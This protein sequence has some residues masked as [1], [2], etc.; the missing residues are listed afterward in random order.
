MTLE[1]IG[2]GGDALLCMIEQPVC[3]Q[4]LYTGAI[5]DDRGNWYFP[6]GTRI[7]SSGDSLDFNR[8]SGQ[9]VVRLNRRQGRVP[10]IYH[11]EIPNEMN[12]TQNIYIGVYNAS[13][14]EWYMYIP[15]TVFIL[16]K[17]TKAYCTC[18]L[19][20]YHCSVVIW[21]EPELAPQ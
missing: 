4:Y 15:A 2:E 10:G 9:V 6:N 11:C 16:L 20:I 19:L 7:N 17:E 8:T 3:C 12:V 21:G 5:D 1:D 14:G 18:N 13:T